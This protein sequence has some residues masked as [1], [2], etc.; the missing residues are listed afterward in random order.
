MEAHQS[1]EDIV[2]DVPGYVAEGPG[3]RMGE[4]DGRSTD[5]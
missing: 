3:R 4:D 1:L 5:V 2:G